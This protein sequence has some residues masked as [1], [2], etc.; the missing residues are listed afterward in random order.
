[1]K[2]RMAP[3]THHGIFPIAA[4]LIDRTGWPVG[5]VSGA[6]HA[7]GPVRTGTDPGWEGQAHDQNMFRRYHRVDRV[8]DR[9]RD[10]PGR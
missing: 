1:M 2:I 3:E 7:G 10:R 6:G 8:R 5:I 4:R 9:F